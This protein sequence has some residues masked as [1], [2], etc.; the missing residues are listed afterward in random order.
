MRKCVSD[1]KC[2][3]RTTCDWVVAEFCW[4]RPQHLATSSLVDYW[5]RPTSATSERDLTPHIRA[6]ILIGGQGE[7]PLDRALL[8]AVMYGKYTSRLIRACGQS[9]GNIE[10]EAKRPATTRMHGLYVGRKP[11]L[12]YGDGWLGWLRAG[13]RFILAPPNEKKLGVVSQRCPKKI[14]RG[15]FIASSAWK[16]VSLTVQCANRNQCWGLRWTWLTS[17]IIGLWP[18]ML[19]TH[20]TRIMSHAMR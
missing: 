20:Y 18:K 15:E 2:Q 13:A 4:C 12:K 10:V 9:T 3:L 16:H 8:L 14:Y 11:G 17:T 7:R 1:D 6:S 5:S 19:K